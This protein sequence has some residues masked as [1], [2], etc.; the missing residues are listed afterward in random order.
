MLK[1]RIVLSGCFVLA[2]LGAGWCAATYSGKPA[3][4]PPPPPP[5]PPGK[6]TYSVESNGLFQMNGDGSGK[7]AVPFTLTDGFP[8][9]SQASYNGHRWWLDILESAPNQTDLYATKD[10]VSWIRLTKSSTT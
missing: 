8:V 5:P 9:P 4:P 2:L 6:I 7:T 3:Q 1:A 10:G